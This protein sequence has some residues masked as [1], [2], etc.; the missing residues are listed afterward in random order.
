MMLKMKI[1]FRIERDKMELKKES[2]RHRD[3]TE[4]RKVIDFQS[5]N[6]KKLHEVLKSKDNEIANLTRENTSL[7]YRIKKLRLKL[8]RL[9]YYEKL[10]KR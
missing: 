5:K 9:E 10:Y 8:E 3:E 2:A 6:F 4:L 7:K 1:L